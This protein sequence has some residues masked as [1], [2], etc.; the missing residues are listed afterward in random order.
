[1]PELFYEIASS[2]PSQVHES[3]IYSVLPVAAEWLAALTSGDELLFIDK[4][5][6]ARVSR[7][8]NDVPKSVSCM[9]VCENA[10]NTV[11]CAG[12]DGVVAIFDMRTGHRVSHFKIG[13]L[14]WSLSHS[15][16]KDR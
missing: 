5:N 9:T 10:K 8:H 1:M 7:H 14:P 11:I 2:S 13:P 4:T 16:C 12:G 15:T 6:L 3:Y